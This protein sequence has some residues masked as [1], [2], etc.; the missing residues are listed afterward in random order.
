MIRNGLEWKGRKNWKVE[1]RDFLGFYAGCW[2]KASVY[3]E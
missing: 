1:A 2:L 3:I